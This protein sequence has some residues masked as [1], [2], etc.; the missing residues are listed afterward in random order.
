MFHLSARAD[1]VIYDDALQNGW[2]NWGWATLNYTNASPVHSGFKSISVT[3]TTSTSE[4]IYIAHTGFDSSPYANLVFWINGGPTGGQQ[5][6]VQGHANGAAQAYTNLPPLAANTWQQFTIPLSVLGVANLPNMDGFWIQDRTGSPQPVFYVDDI[7]LQAGAPVQPSTNA[8]V[9]VQVDALANRQVISPL[10]YGVAFASSNEVGDLNFTVNRSG[11][12]SETRYNWQL[13]AHNHAADWYFESIDDGSA[14]PGASADDFVANSKAGGAQPMITIPMIGWMPRLGSSRGKLASYSIAKYGPQTGDDAQ[15]YPDAGNGMASPSGAAI[16]SN[17]PNDAN[18]P[19]N[20]AFQ[21][22]FV[23]HLT[24]RWGAST[25]GGVHYYFMDNE[26]SIWFSTH[27]DVHPAGPTMAEIRDKIFDYASMVKSNDPNALVLGPEEW[28][29]SGYFYSGYDQQNAGFNDRSNNGG[30]D[31]MPWLLDQIHQHDLGTGQRLLDYFTLHCYPQ[32]GEGGNDVSAPTQLLRNQSTRQFWDT[33]YVDQSWIGQQATNTILM[34]IPRMKKWV[35][36]YYPGT[37]IGVT[38]YNWGAEAYINGATAQADILG[39]FGR[40]SLDLAT[41]WTTPTNASPTYK[42]MK[43]YRNYDGNKSSFGDTSVA[44][45]VPNPDNLS[46]FAA[47]RTNDSALTIMVINKTLTGLTPLALS[48]TNFANSGTAQAWQLTASNV[49]ARLADFPYAGGIVSN[50]LPPQSITLFVLPTAKN[51]RL[52]VGTNAAPRQMELWL[53]GQGGQRYVLESSTNLTTW[54][55]IST[56][57]FSSNSFQIF[58]GTT[59]PAGM[60][61]RSL[62]SPP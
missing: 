24:G 4:A 17:D 23:Q 16:T 10:I 41:R 20:S 61:Y 46:A 18:F 48:V 8:T 21:K 3:I 34:L 28:G 37:K 51:L 53:D 50:Q 11:G 38:E 14:T 13:N 33:N 47:I 55:A 49:I 6:K 7:S 30:W 57:M 29:W 25:N 59:N 42:A 5:L 9:T 62:L 27:Q 22:M 26:H 43:L 1:Q 52:R 44:A 56:N 54:S 31:Y 45:T 2:Q 36:S 32:G 12:N 35:A 39:I 19:T 58:I 15:W 40:E 60:F